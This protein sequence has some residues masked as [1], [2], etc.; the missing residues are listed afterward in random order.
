MQEYTRCHLLFVPRS[1]SSQEQA[2]AIRQTRGA[3]VLL[4]GDSAGFAEQRGGVGFYIEQNKVRFAISTAAA[5]EQHLKIS[6]K[7]LALAKLVDR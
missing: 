1:A 4:V 5:N 6:S 3:P 2:A 7:L